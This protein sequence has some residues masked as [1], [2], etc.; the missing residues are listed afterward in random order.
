MAAPYSTPDTARLA[1][2]VH[3]FDSDGIAQRYHV[4]GSGPVCLAHP[5]GPGIH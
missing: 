1:P 4:Y 2:G 5:G 3:T